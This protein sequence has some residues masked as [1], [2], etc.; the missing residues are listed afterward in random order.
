MFLCGFGSLLVQDGPVVGQGRK[1]ISAGRASAS[2]S[3][4]HQQLW[5]ARASQ[6]PPPAAV[7]VQKQPLRCPPNN[8]AGQQVPATCRGAFGVREGELRGSHARCVLGLWATGGLAAGFKAHVWSLALFLA[9]A[10]GLAML[11][12]LLMTLILTLYRFAVLKG[13][14]WPGGVKSI[15]GGSGA[16]GRTGGAWGIARC[17]ALDEG[18][19][20]QMRGVVAAKG[21]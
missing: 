18:T 5:E 6:N 12:C 19:V 13:C 8:P 4:S 16:S 7:W 17:R 1:M 2:T 11:V 21:S 10:P 15:P 3:A 14:V 20:E 9:G